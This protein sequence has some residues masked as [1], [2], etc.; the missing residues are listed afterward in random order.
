MLFTCKFMRFRVIT[1]Y[2][3]FVIHTEDQTYYVPWQTNFQANK[4]HHRN[5]VNETISNC[6][7]K[8]L[9]IALCS[10]NWE[11]PLGDAA[12]SHIQFLYHCYI[13]NVKE[14]KSRFKLIVMVNH[15]QDSTNNKHS[16]NKGMT[17]NVRLWQLSTKAE[18]INKVLYSQNKH[19]CCLLFF[20]IMMCICVLRFTLHYINFR[21]S[22]KFVYSPL[23][24][25][26]KCIVI[27][28]TVSHLVTVKEQ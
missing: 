9:Y 5:D 6:H 24:F 15:S 7:S 2:V 10:S 28:S 3:S 1:K 14:S 22:R 13:T 19:L 4:V 17:I 18:S 21:W 20:Q 12:I 23:S 25:H 11:F 16:I 8:I 27:H 26:Y